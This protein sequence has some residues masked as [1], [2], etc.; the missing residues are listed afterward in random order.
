MALKTFTVGEVLTAADTNLYLVNTLAVRKTAT[1]QVTSSTTLQNDDELLLSV[2]A[3]S[4]YEFSGM[5]IFDG[6]TAGDLKYQFTGPASAT[7]DA[8]ANQITEAG[9]I[10]SS[11]QVIGFN[12]STPVITGA[13]GTGTNVHVPMSGILVVAGTAGTFQL[14]WAQ[15]TSSVTGTRI[16]ANSYLVLRRIL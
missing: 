11:D 10:S 2:A 6:A 9:T 4:T 12:I 13:V 16:F 14:Q 3:N 1:E 15:G 5:L 8:V 7:L